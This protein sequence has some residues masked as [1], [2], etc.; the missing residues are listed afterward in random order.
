MELT[1]F[2]FF[3]FFCI[4]T[5]F[6]SQRCEK[7]V[8]RCCCRHCWCGGSVQGM[9]PWG[10]LGGCCDAEKGAAL[11]G[12]CL[13]VSCLRTNQLDNSSV[14]VHL[15]RESVHDLL[16]HNLATFVVK[17]SIYNTRASWQSLCRLLLP[18]IFFRYSGTASG[19]IF[20]LF[21]PSVRGLL[22]FS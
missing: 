11:L 15:S 13:G 19:S 6:L 4:T 17:L 8:Q 9:Q 22:A 7:H 21:N 1:S 16:I 10:S 2:L 18:V 5:L 12:R 14:S 20:K 3:L